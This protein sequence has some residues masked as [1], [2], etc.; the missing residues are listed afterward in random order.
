VFHFTA[1][2]VGITLNYFLAYLASRTVGLNDLAASFAASSYMFWIGALRCLPNVRLCILHMRNNLLNYKGNMYFDL[3]NDNFR[4]AILS[5]GGVWIGLTLALTEVSLTQ[6]GSW[7]A[8]LGLLAAMLPFTYP[9]IAFPTCVYMAARLLFG[10]FDGVSLLDAGFFLIG[11]VPVMLWSHARGSIRAFLKAVIS[12]PDMMA[13]MHLDKISLSAKTSWKS[14]FRT[15]RKGPLPLALVSLFISIFMPG[16]LLLLMNSAALVVAVILAL[17]QFQSKMKVLAGRI[18]ERGG[19]SFHSLVFFVTLGGIL[20]VSHDAWLNA[21]LIVCLAVPTLGLL[22]MCATHARNQT[23][24]M[25]R[26]RW[27]ALRWLGRHVPNDATVCCLDVADMQLQPVYTSGQA[28]IG[29]AEWLQSPTLAL[30]RYFKVLTLCGISHELVHDW[31]CDFA[32]SKAKFQQPLTAPRSDEAEVEGVVFLN[33]MLYQP[34]LKMCDNIPI[35]DE[36][37]GWSQAFLK[38]LNSLSTQA[39]GCEQN[40][41]KPDFIL[42]SERLQQRRNKQE[43]NP[44]GYVA[45]A[46]FAGITVYQRQGLAKT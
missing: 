27:E 43:A 16:N 12:P 32:V 9:G 10:Y 18:Y 19:L 23:Y 44:R 39:A 28:Y 3:I 29:G 5:T 22:R 26:H 45:A 37:G 20:Q 6:H 17:S 24:C 1:F 40:E 38:H 14:H 30:S 34:Y 35:T 4:Y 2:L 25:D 13:D 21:A 31:V 36:S 7:F 46:S 42:L 8:S 41:S 11:F 33:R 15:A